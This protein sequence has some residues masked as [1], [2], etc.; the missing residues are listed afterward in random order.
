M[1][2]SITYLKARLEAFSNPDLMP[3]DC[4][5]LLIKYYGT[6]RVET[7]KP[8]TIYTKIKSMMQLHVAE[9]DEQRIIETVNNYIND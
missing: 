7:M 3:I 4:L 6:A 2:T 8:E 9:P 5:D 1:K